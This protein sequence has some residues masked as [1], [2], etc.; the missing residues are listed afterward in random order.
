MKTLTLFKLLVPSRVSWWMTIPCNSL[1]FEEVPLTMTGKSKECFGMAC[2]WFK[3]LQSAKKGAI[4]TMSNINWHKM[5]AS[6]LLTKIGKMPHGRWQPLPT[7]WEQH[8]SPQQKWTPWIYQQSV[9]RG[10]KDPRSNK[11]R[12][13][14]CKVKSLRG[15]QQWQ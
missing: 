6:S 2:W 5:T 8:N 3:G 14:W 4:V 7:K 9:Q 15:W 11:T 1:Q 12:S 13:I 10:T